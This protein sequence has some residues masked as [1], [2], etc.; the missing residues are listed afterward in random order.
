[1]KDAQIVRSDG[2]VMTARIKIINA[3]TPIP[4]MYTW[5]PIQ[6]NFMVLIE[7]VYIYENECLSVY[8]LCTAEPI[9]LKLNI[10]IAH[11]PT[12]SPVE[13]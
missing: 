11:A 7:L 13:F 5:A 10:V 6:Q 4:T 8:S 2:V 9:E 1:M 3:V 12:S